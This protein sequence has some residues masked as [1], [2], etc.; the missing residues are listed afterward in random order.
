MTGSIVITDISS[1]VFI[2]MWF[3]SESSFWFFSHLNRKGGVPCFSI[4]ATEA[5][6]WTCTVFGKIKGRTFGE[7]EN[8]R[9][10]IVNKVKIILLNGTINAFCKL[11]LKNPIDLVVNLNTLDFIVSESLTI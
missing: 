7:S 4:Q 6:S 2:L 9:K 5:F 10:I 8:K 11:D 3:D 1:N